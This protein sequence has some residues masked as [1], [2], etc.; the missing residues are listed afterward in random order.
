MMETIS[1]K[2]FSALAEELVQYRMLQNFLL[3][4]GNLLKLD[5][6]T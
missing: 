4:T 1:G 6:K 5:I 2:E 3:H